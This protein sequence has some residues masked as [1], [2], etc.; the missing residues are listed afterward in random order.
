MPPSDK[1]VVFIHRAIF[2]LAFR[3]KSGCQKLII[4]AMGS[5]ILSK[6]RIYLEI[7]D[8]LTIYSSYGTPWVLTASMAAI[9]WRW[10]TV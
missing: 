8:T 2:D 3:I 4:Y 1:R 7:Q 9:P 5:L 6:A 10:E